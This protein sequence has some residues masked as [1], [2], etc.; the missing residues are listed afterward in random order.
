MLGE[1]VRLS[2]ALASE[3]PLSGVAVPGN[4]PGDSAGS[5]SHAAVLGVHV[6][7]LT[8]FA[9]P[10]G[11]GPH[12]LVTGTARSGKSTLLRTWACS[13]A[14]G[15]DARRLRLYVIDSRR[16]GLAALQTLAPVVG[17]SSEPGEGERLLETVEAELHRLPAP[18]VV[19]V[20]DF[21]DNY[22]D[23]LTDVGRERLAALM[24]LGRNR[25]FHVLLA[26][27]TSDLSAKSY[28]DPVKSLKEAQVGFMLGSGDDMIL[29]TR[30]PYAERSKLLPVGEG[31]YVNRT[32]TRRIKVAVADAELLGVS[33]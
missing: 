16:Q 20:D 26:G 2:D 15:P 11:A 8:R 23:G 33:A 31:Y 9:L 27:R 21:G 12:F 25:P 17:Y 10:L 13:L 14:R 7:D 22:D 1:V 28:V 5:E 30:L 24:R 32:V 3:L 19:I 4:G 29:N 18:V 6:D